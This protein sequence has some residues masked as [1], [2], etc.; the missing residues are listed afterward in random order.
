MSIIKIS[1]QTEAASYF[2][3][4]EKNKKARER[5]NKWG[6]RHPAGHNQKVM[7]RGLNSRA[8][9]P[10]VPRL[11]YLPHWYNNVTN[12]MGIRFLKTKVKSWRWII[13]ILPCGF[14][15]YSAYEKISSNWYQLCCSVFYTKVHELMPQWSSHEW[16]QL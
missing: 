9:G 2:S 11:R 12:H 5:Q 13:L 16:C 8:T 14:H 6:I 7:Q 4:W 1:W 10:S 15:F 3:T